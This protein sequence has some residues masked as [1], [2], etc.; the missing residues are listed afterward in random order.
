MLENLKSS[1]QN[2]VSEDIKTTIQTLS[3]DEAEKLCNNVAQ[4]F[5]FTDY[6][7]DNIRVVS[8]AGFHCPCG[9]THCKSTGDLKARGWG[10]KGPIKSKK[11]VVRLRYGPDLA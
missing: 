1:F 4:N 2:L 6:S 10:I 11:G 9:G 5:D 7:G 3:K 8:V